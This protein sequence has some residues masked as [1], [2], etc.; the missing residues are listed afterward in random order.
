[1]GD[2]VLEFKDLINIKYIPEINE[3]S[4]KLLIDFYEKYLCKKVFV[5]PLSNGEI[6]KLFFK[7]TLKMQHIH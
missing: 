7:V 4:L 6:V 5:F 3:I 2:K 1:M